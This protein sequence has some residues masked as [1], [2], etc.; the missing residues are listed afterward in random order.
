[1]TNPP[2]RHAIL[3]AL[4]AFAPPAPLRSPTLAL[5]ATLGYR[6]SRT[7]VID[8]P[9]AA[10]L[11]ALFAIRLD[12]QRAL[13]A[14]WDAVE[15][16]FQLTDA[17][18]QALGAQQPLPFDS[19]QPVDDTRMQSYL[20]LA[21]RLRAAHYSRTALAGITREIN[22]HFP[23]PLLVLFQ[24]GA[25]LTIA[26]INRR[27]HRHHAARDVLQKV[28]LIKD[29]DVGQPH[30]AHLDILYDLAWPV[31]A[32]EQPPRNFVELQHAWER[33]LSSSELNKRFYREIADWY[34]WATQQV[35]FPPGG[36]PDAE[37]RNAIAI[38]RLITR[39]IFVWFLKE[40]G[41]VPADL[42]NEHKLS[43]LLK[44][45]SPDASS[46]Y[47]AILQNLFFATLNQEMGQRAFRTRRSDG[48][49]QHR[50]V[51][52]LYRYEDYFQ[53]G[54]AEQLLALMQPIPFL[55]GGL[56]E[57]L[58]HEDEQRQ[59]VR[60]D[61]FS[62]EPKNPLVV[63]NR[64]FFGAEQAVDLHRFYGTSGRPQQVRGLIHIFNRYKFTV[65]ENTPIEEEIALDPELLGQVFENLLAAYNPETGA[66][67]RKQTGA[68]YTP[69][70]IV[71]YMVDEALLA[72][73]G[74]HLCQ[75]APQPSG[76]DAPAPDTLTR[77]L[78]HLLSYT[79]EPPQFGPDETNTLLMAIDQ[80]KI[81]DPAC[82]S[83]AFPMG[84]L[85]KLVFLLGKLDPGNQRWKQ[86]QIDNL[87]ED[88]RKAGRI[89][90]AQVRENA[91]DLLEQK[92]DA[93]ERAFAYD[94]LDYARKLY[95]IQ[96]CIYGVD[97]QP[98]AVQIAKL[99][100]FIALI[101]DQQTDEQLENR[102]ILALPNLETRFVAANTLLGMAVSQGALRSQAVL[103]LEQE[104]ATV[105]QRHF[106]ARTP[107]TKRKYRDEDRRIRQQIGV[108]LKQD[109]VPGATADLLARWDPYDQNASAE[110]FDPGWMFSIEGG[111]DIVLGNPPYVRHEQIRDQ[112]PRLKERYTCYT[113]TADLYVYFYERGLQLLNPGGVL[114]YISSNKY[115][116][117]GYG[118]KLRHYLAS[119]TSIE[120]L[121]D[122]GDAPIFTAIAYPSIIIARKTAPNANQ[123]RTLT[124]TP[125]QP[126]DEFVQVWRAHSFLLAQQ[127]LQAD[128]WQLEAPAV[129]RL[130]DKL[131]NAGTPLGEYVR[132]RL[133]YGIKT[134]L[135]EAF[136][137][138]RATRDQLIAA[139]PS[140]AEV[141]KP[142]LR[143]RDVKRWCVE[144]PDLWLI[145]IP[146]HFPLH[147]DTTITGA[148][149][150]AEQAFERHYPVIYDHLHKFQKELSARN[151]TETG[152]R[153]EWYA[154]QRCA[155]T[156]WQE[157]EQ[158]KIVIPA[159]IRNVAYAPDF[160]TC[161][162]ND[163]T[164]I[165]VT[166][167]ISY[168]LGLLNSQV[169][170]WF[171][172]QIAATKQ[173]GFYE[174]K[175]M[176]VSRLP[177]PTIDADAKKPI[178]TLVER[179]LA[180]KRSDPRA[181]VSGL[182]AEIDAHVYRLYGL[183]PEEIALVEG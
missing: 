24:H 113:G 138:D 72:Y 16:L 177:I 141:L 75:A 57:C 95:L 100:C 178:E 145:F 34:F 92:R 156:Y 117:A 136:V 81:L 40:K 9:T 60:I 106:D 130:L 56:F 22:R 2:D 151:K 179:I 152:V 76:Q 88:M 8:P 66:T 5:F 85:Q 93:I 97:I 147:A 96:N 36:E 180:T 116:R 173:G 14:E 168:L 82:G 163:K 112:K 101:V 160:D 54:G 17:E 65:T 166:T 164:S 104:L 107:R 159:I 13:T 3:K 69:R 132:G 162:S 105:R 119:K 11:Q 98:I 108:E 58:D 45:F 31:L 63:P 126:L 70:E 135:N 23:M 26:I 155:A 170:W 142:Y 67:A 29:I 99:R 73:L 51:T 134:G 103:R 174:F 77:R 102:G 158:P 44:D 55:N 91:L 27:M 7:L 46:Y 115:F 123:T 133:Y 150:E 38:I 15:F 86:R 94:A 61:G 43:A 182:E 121:I 49:D 110:F 157:F 37:Q 10:G 172:Q 129:L 74:Q 41:L 42:F 68:F 109:G 84:V 78:R 1:M 20:F 32:H 124:W 144:S 149:K 137:V 146:W 4:N 53:A 89:Q 64:L 52:N 35:V 12:P 87:E 80:V 131:R 33:V 175:P 79:D 183:T 139:H 127:E 154:L 153:Y 111:F 176:Y 161:F 59:V 118:K 114:S 140:S 47:R 171:M 30:R 48:R 90:D 143:G 39:L 120:Q 6:S 25:T 122:F 181:D 167:D 28:T 169:L 148:S 18:M 165:C 128:G 50:L 19:T 71:N 21:I 62:D 83:G 125:G